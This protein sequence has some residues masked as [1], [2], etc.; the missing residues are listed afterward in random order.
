[1]PG[2]E[3]V[4]SKAL[5]IP[6]CPDVSGDVLSSR[7]QPPHAESVVCFGPDPEYAARRSSILEIYGWSW[8]RLQVAL[9]GAMDCRTA[10]L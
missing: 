7:A 6:E 9:S 5:L 2:V 1:M 10:R 4:V 8:D 3:V